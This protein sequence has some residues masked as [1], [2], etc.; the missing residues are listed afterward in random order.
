MKSPQPTFATAGIRSRQRYPRIEALPDAQRY[1]VIRQT[2]Q[3]MPDSITDGHE[4][5]QIHSRLIR[6]LLDQVGSQTEDSPTRSL[7]QVPTDEPVAK[8]PTHG[9]HEIEDS[10]EAVAS[11][12]SVLSELGASGCLIIIG[13]EHFVW[14][15]AQQGQQ[16]GL[17]SDDMLMVPVSSLGR[18]VFCV[19]C[20]HVSEH[21]VH[22]PAACDG[23]GLVLEVRDH[24]SKRLGAYM[25][26]RIDAEAPGEIPPQE[27]VAPCLAS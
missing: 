1:L 14:Q 27:E 10:L 26:V 2:F 15:V 21:V 7:A 5:L 13:S 3:D 9:W 18:H 11:L 25:G 22:S 20:Q 23:C 12:E 4:P 19:H 16:Q 6:S 24:F 8:A 17:M